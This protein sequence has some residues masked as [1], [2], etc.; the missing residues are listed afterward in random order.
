MS[1]EAAEVLAFCDR[2]KSAGCY[3]IAIAGRQGSILV[4]RGDISLD[5]SVESEACPLDLAPTSCVLVAIALGDALAVSTV[6][7]A[8]R[9]RL[10]L[11]FWY[12][13]SPPLTFGP[14]CSV[15]GRNEFS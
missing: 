14:G 7:C 5:G 11:A 4:N 6:D 9:R 13:L 1:G 15:N 8:T 2:L 3:T 10:W 12:S